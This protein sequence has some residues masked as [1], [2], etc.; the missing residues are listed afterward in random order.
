[1]LLVSDTRQPILVMQRFLVYLDEMMVMN[2][3][4]LRC[5]WTW[6]RVKTLYSKYDVTFILTLGDCR[7][8]TKIPHAVSEPMIDYQQRL[9]ISYNRL[10]MIDHP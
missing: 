1:M 4:K 8:T 10:D 9:V 3:E 6:I 7:G 2:T 5:T